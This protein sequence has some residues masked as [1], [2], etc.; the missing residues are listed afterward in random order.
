MAMSTVDFA[1]PASEAE[2]EALAGRLRERNFEVVI[3]QNGEE[4]K[5]EVMKR[6]PE[7]AKVHSG[8]SKTL[9][10]AGL[11]KEF[12]ENERYD[13]VRRTTMKMDQRTQRDEMRKLGAAPDVMVNSAHAVTEAGQIVITSASGSQIGPIASGAGKL[14][15]VIGAQKI[16]PDL[17]TAF[18]RIE[19]YVFPYEDARLREVLGVGTQIT[20]T[21]IL[22]RDFVPGRTTIVL[23]R[24]PIGV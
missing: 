24:D 16:V 2:L 18:R 5:A 4:A 3:V 21:L 13:F 7:G 20:R 11:F 8:K 22:E 6:I 1:A 17:D 19:E 23:V 9:E 12:M 14:I 15:L 10:D